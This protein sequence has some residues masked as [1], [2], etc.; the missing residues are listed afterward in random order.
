MLLNIDN[1]DLFISLFDR[2]KHTYI[3]GQSGSGKTEFMK[4]LFLLHI[5]ENLNSVSRNT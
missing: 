2:Y 1:L 3:T 5:T 4:T